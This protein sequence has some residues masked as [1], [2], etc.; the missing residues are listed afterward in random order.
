M[1][2]MDRAWLHLMLY[3]GLRTCEVRRLRLGDIQWESQRLHFEQS[4][5]LKDRLVSWLPSV[6]SVVSLL[7]RSWWAMPG[8]ACYGKVNKIPS[9]FGAYCSRF[10]LS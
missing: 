2:I 9:E 7:P 3:S 6:R 10:S 1:G 8:W 4:K 5:G